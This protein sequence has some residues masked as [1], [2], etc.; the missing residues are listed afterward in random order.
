MTNPTPSSTPTG[1][2][3]YCWNDI[4]DLADLASDL[5]GM[6]DLEAELH[7]NRFR[8]GYNLDSQASSVNNFE[9][10]PAAWIHG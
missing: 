4:N 3:R 1:P 6:T 8:P 10:D 7:E 2:C 5:T 9:A